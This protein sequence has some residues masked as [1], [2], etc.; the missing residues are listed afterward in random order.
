MLGT[1]LAALLLAGCGDDD[2]D[3]DASPAS[4]D[5]AAAGASPDVD[6]YCAAA[7]AGETAG[8]PDVDFETATDDEIAAAAKEFASETLA[9]LADDLVASAPAEISADVDVLV[10]AVGEIAETGDFGAFETPDVAAANERV[11]A[12]DLENCGWATLDVVTVDY[13]FDGIP[14]EVAAGPTS[15]ELTNDGPE[16]H[17]I[18]LL[19]KND[20]VTESFDELLALPEEEAGDKVTFTGVAGPVPAGEGAYLVADLE[21]GEYLALCFLPVGTTSMDGGPPPEGPPHFMSGMTQEFT[22]A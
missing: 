1:S 2:G 5:A 22:V 9:P 21:P 4:G 13:A 7:L 17:E 12:F 11:H 18:A 15:F 6:G 10:A 20:G 14:A 16:V 3:D 19:R 8:F